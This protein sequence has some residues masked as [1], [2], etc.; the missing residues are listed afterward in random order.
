M[1]DRDLIRA[2]MHYTITDRFRARSLWKGKHRQGI[3]RYAVF[4][5]AAER[6]A[7]A[8]QLTGSLTHADAIR[9]RE[10]FIVDALLEIMADERTPLAMCNA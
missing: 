8:I 7:P 10:N 3:A 5:D 2:Q 1:S 6:G 4:T 9:A